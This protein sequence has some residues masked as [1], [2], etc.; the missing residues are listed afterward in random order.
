MVEFRILVDLVVAADTQ[1][2]VRDSL[3]SCGVDFG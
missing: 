2:E 1:V 3:G